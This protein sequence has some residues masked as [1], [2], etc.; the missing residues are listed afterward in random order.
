MLPYLLGGDLYPGGLHTNSALNPADAPSRDK[1]VPEP[2]RDRPAWLDDL[3]R[4]SVTRFDA[5]LGSS[6]VP[7]VLGRWVRLLLLLPGGV[8]PEPGPC[9]G[10]G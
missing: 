8:A 7:R 5:V 1:A 10:D 9:G 3:A 4:G 2:S 6:A